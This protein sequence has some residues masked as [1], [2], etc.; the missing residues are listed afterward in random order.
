MGDR[1]TGCH[2]R[3]TAVASWGRVPMKVPNSASAAR[4]DFQSHAFTQSWEMNDNQENRNGRPHGKDERVLQAWVCSSRLA[5]EETEAQSSDVAHQGPMSS[6]GQSPVSWAML[7]SN[8][9]NS[10]AS[11]PSRGHWSSCLFNPLPFF[12]VG[13]KGT[14]YYPLWSGLQCPKV[15]ALRVVWGG[16]SDHLL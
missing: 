5:E 6:P 7:F 11:R 4:K 10:P 16:A 8:L 15:L 9:C 14:H 13:Y 2:V 12:L 1:Q 3:N